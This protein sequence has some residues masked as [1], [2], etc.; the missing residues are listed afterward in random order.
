MKVQNIQSQ[1]TSFNGLIMPKKMTFYRPAWGREVLS[2]EDVLANKSIKENA[3]KFDVVIKKQKTSKRRSLSEIEVSRILTGGTGIGALAGLA[4]A[5]VE[6]VVNPAAF[7]VATF[8]GAM[9][10][11]SMGWL[12]ANCMDDFGLTPKQHKYKLQVGKN[13]NEKTGKFDKTIV[14]EHSI[15]DASDIR[16]IKIDKSGQILKDE[17]FKIRLS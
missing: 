3:E 4:I 14:E 10:G 2:R 9:F 15:E 11:L 17:Y 6:G 1:N 7:L 12:T 16:D 13:Y 8:G 5:F